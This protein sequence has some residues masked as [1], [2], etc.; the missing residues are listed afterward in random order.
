[1][2]RTVL[3]VKIKRGE[4]VDKALKRLK[5]ML[6]KEGLMKEIRGHRYFEKPC[7]KRRKKA[8]RARVR[9]RYAV[10]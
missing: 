10:T 8:A 2:I 9:Q 5:K 1:V 6:D 7:E 3:Q 4:P